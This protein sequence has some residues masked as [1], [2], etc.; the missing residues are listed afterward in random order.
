MAHAKII[1]C[2]RNPLDNILSMLRNNLSPGNDYT[3]SSRESAL[4]LIEQEK[5]ML[6]YKRKWP[7]Q[8]YTFNYDK[9]VAMPREM[10]KPLTEWL[11]LSWD[12]NFL[13]PETNDRSINTASVV[14]ARQPIN[15]NSLGG[16][17]NYRDLLEPG[18][19]LILKSGLFN[20]FDLD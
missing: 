20:E 15:K 7:N 18:R 9:F 8:I 5:S 4:V 14:Q 3:T 16:W 2:R 19:Q 11:Q 12:E 10:I 17:K 13:H 6:Q 1:H